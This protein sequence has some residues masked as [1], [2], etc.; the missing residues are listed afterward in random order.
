[1]SNILEE[2]EAIE[3]D[4]RDKL[5]ALDDLKRKQVESLRKACDHDLGK[6]EGFYFKDGAQACKRGCGLCGFDEFMSFDRYLRESQEEAEI[7]RDEINR[8]T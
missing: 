5:K 4:H 7:L 1:M 8:L 3:S 2:I 6:W